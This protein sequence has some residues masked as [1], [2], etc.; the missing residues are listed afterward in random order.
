MPDDARTTACFRPVADPLPN[1][2]HVGYISSELPKKECVP[3]K[4]SISV[5]LGQVN[6][7]LR[8]ADL[9]ELAK[10]HQTEQEA[11]TWLGPHARRDPPISELWKHL[12]SQWQET[13]R[14]LSN[15]ISANEENVQGLTVRA[16]E[17]ASQKYSQNSLLCST[18]ARGVFA[19]GKQESDPIL[20]GHIIRFFVGL[21]IQQGDYKENPASK[22]DTDDHRGG[23]RFGKN[24]PGW[25]A[26]RTGGQHIIANY[27]FRFE[28]ST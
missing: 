28:L 1:R 14:D 4:K 9:D 24:F 19:L 5:D 22:K 10:W 3:K 2:I 13:D 6:G 8:F 17:T 21:G 18:S 25:F 11:W 23:K 20:S 16:V 12:N 7:E 26:V 27:D 15:A